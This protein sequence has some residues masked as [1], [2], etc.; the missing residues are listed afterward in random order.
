[1]NE[2]PPHQARHWVRIETGF[3]QP[4]GN[5]ENISIEYFTFEDA[6]EFEDFKAQKDAEG[7]KYITGGN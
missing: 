6:A 2:N 4:V 7:V 5:G 1:M 3:D